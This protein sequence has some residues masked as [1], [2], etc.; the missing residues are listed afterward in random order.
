M[1]NKT[2][3]HSFLSALGVF[4][5]VSVVAWIMTN[6]ERLFVDAPEFWMP[7]VMLLLLVLSVAVMGLLIFGRPVY[8]F[9]S[10]SK[11][12]AIKLLF[13]TISWLTVIVIIVLAF[14]LS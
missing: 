3:L 2:V 7:V 9:Q 1:N 12:E 13:M 5:Y 8:L 4:I 11:L 6:G 10:G 14:M